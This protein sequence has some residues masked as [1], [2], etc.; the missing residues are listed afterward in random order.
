MT[1][2]DREVAIDAILRKAVVLE[3][4]I[5]QLM[6]GSLAELGHL[7]LDARPIDIAPLLRAATAFTSA[8]SATHEFVIDVEPG[9]PRVRADEHA[10]ESVLAQLLENAVKYSPDGG[11]I[12]VRAIAG[13][14]DVAVSVSDE[15][16]GLRPGDEERV[17]DRFARGSSGARGV[18][19]GLFIVQ[20][21]VEAQRGRVWASRHDGPGATFSFS[22]PRD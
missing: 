20:R 3:R 8:T 17:F 5:D 4:T 9:L 19:L 14:D 15:G 21:L 12:T 16:V 2:E 11:T 6:A 22:L 1:P 7:D 18:G 13:R 10:V